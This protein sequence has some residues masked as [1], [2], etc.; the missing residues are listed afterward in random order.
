MS[1]LQTAS[2]AASIA[3][4]VG[5]GLFA[6][7]WSRKM[8]ERNKDAEF[9]L[10]ARNS[11]GTGKIIWSFYAAAVGAWT[12]FGPPSYAL[13]A[14]ILGVIFYAVACGIPIFIVAFFGEKIQ[15]RFPKVLS[16]ADF[17]SQRFGRTLEVLVSIIMIFN[18]GIALT[19]EY[20][21]IGDLFET[22]VGTNRIPIV[23]VIGC[24]TMIYTATGGLSVS[25][26][27]DQIQGLFSIIFVTVMAIYIAATFRMPLSAELPAELAPN[28]LGYSAIA[29]MPISL[30]CSTIYNEAMWQRVWASADDK[31]LR[32]GALVSMTVVTIII[33][34]YGFCG[35]LAAWAGLTI[36]NPNTVLFTLLG[37]GGEAPV[38]IIVIVTVLAATMNQSAVD[39]LQNALVDNISSLLLRGRS[40]WWS[41]LVVVIVNVPLVVV[42]LRGYQVMNLFLVANLVATCCAAPI[43]LGLS[44]RLEA[45]VTTASVIVGWITGFV[46]VMV[47]GYLKVGDVA[48]GLHYTFFE[49]YDYPSFLLA[50][51][52]SVVGVFLWGVPAQLLTHGFSSK[53]P[54]SITKSTTLRASLDEKH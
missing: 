20:T 36:D 34:F 37:A 33:F 7:V 39:S 23:I 21:S 54:S 31:T 30:T 53:A 52:F 12:L 15:S 50:L 47:F 51:G 3:V 26:I 42:S 40:V 38:W 8:Q 16:L 17:V 49:V 45:Y 22:V 44:R 27:T 29:V 2:Y 28:Y 11:Q 19:A 35:F 6:L 46:A 14:G 9:F 43:L 4:C 5:F 10:T 1:T 41:R 13:S 48:G 25:I 32:T 24:T 18:M